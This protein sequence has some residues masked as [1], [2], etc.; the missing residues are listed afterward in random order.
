MKLKRWN[1]FLNEEESSSK[2]F[3]D[4]SKKEF[5]CRPCSIFLDVR[6]LKNGKCPICGSDED[7]YLNDLTE[8]E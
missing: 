5:V 3:G 8:E 4:N 6:D 7:V 2:I 1:D